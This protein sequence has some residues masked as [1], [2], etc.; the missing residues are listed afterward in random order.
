MPW[1][2]AHKRQNKKPHLSRLKK[3]SVLSIGKANNERIIKHV[4][5]GAVTATSTD[6]INGSQLYAVADEFSKLAVNV[7]GAEVEDASKTGFKKSEFTAL[8]SSPSTSTTPPQPQ[9]QTQ[10]TQKTAM[11][12]KDAIE[13][14]ITKLNSGF[15]FGSGDE[16]GEQRTHYLGDKLII[17]AGAVDK[18]TSTSDDGYSHRIILKQRI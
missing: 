10:T 18:P 9:G 17:K 12:F 5:A 3:K 15:V 2:K 16:S 8:L 11:T 1:G 7:L 4:A 6:A 14:N 13:A